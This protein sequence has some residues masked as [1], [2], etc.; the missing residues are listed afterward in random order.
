MDEQERYGMGWVAT[1]RSVAEAMRLDER[2]EDMTLREF[3]CGERGSL[4]GD[5]GD[6]E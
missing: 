3:A 2:T 5:E 1:G 4:F 6:D